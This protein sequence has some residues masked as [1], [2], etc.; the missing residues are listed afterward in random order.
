MAESPR[1]RILAHVR[2][3][4]ICCVIGLALNFMWC[5]LE[6]H[7]LRFAETAAQFQFPLN[8]R[9]F[10]L[11]G[12]CLLALLYLAV[13]HWL[14]RWENTLKGIVPL[15]GAA[16][17]LAFATAPLQS[18]VPPLA[19]GLAG[20]AVSGLGYFWFA[21]RCF[22]LMARARS[23]MA[24]A[25]AIVAAVLLKTFLLPVA[26][27][28]LDSEAQVVFACAIPILSSLLLWIAQLSLGV[29]A[30]FSLARPMRAGR[31]SLPAQRNFILLLILSAFLLATVRR[32]SFWG[33]WGETSTFSIAP[34]W[35]LPELAIMA[36]CLAA[37]VWGAFAR[38]ASLP[39][40]FRFQPAIV[41]VVTGLFIAAMA[42]PAQNVLVSTAVAIII[43]VDEACA[44]LLFWTVVALSLDTLDIPPFRVLGIGG[45]IYA[46]S[47]LI[48][49]AA[50]SHIADMGGALVTLA[51]YV[52][53]MALM[54]YT[55]R[56]TK[57]STDESGR[58]EDGYSPQVPNTD[59][60]R[61]ELED[62]GSITD[63]IAERC[64]VLSERYHLTHREK[65]VLSLLA[66]GRTRAYIQEELVLSVS[67]VKTHISHIYAK[68]GVH[69]RQGVMDLVLKKESDD[70]ET[71]PR[72]L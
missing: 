28:L 36:A 63:S 46:G 70:S 60:G 67:T 31:I 41:V 15:C 25:W 20:L 2:L 42:Q 17:T 10:W 21:S 69:D 62:P 65:E 64:K 47:S 52:G 53:I 48:W 8:P 51:A 39:V 5:S 1:R 37:F 23:I 7:A 24:I 29:T 72:A 14:K 66:Q 61:E 19:L 18:A 49:V 27:D 22:T 13:P 3:A 26:T 35:G 34:L 12:F 45:L 56:E 9:G 55:Y 16:G 71:S 11:M 57:I 59:R 30:V 54:W 6:G 43:H 50:G 58:H 33:T 44:Y 32:L 38:T 4:D 68:L 40:A